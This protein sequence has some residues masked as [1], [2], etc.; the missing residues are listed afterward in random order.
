M[1]IVKPE[2]NGFDELEKKIKRI[3]EGAKEL[4]QTKDIQFNE[5][6]NDAFMAKNT[7]FNN[8]DDF[9]GKSPFDV[10]SRETFKEIDEN[11]LDHYVVENSDF[12]SWTEMMNAAT[13][14]FIFKKLGL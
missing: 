3:E 1:S 4:E 7:P 5:L 14:E 8:V 12:D 6:F 10:T 9:F 2:V 11:K 13:E